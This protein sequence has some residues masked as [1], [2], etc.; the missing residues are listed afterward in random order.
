MDTVRASRS[1]STKSHKEPKVIPYKFGLVENDL[2]ETSEQHK[3]KNI[4]KA[5]MKTRKQENIGSFTVVND[6]QELKQVVVSQDV[7]SHYSGETKHSKNL[8]LD[9]IGGLEVY[10]TNDP[11]I[12]KLPDGSTLRKTNS[13]RLNR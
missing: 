10:K 8:Y 4:W 6:H 13:S 2:Q 1:V 5:D 7:I 11:N 12:F 9:K 3:T